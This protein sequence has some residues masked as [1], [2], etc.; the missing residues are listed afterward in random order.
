MS[1]PPQYSWPA[2]KRCA[3]VVSVLFDDG[4]DAV[5]IAPDLPSRSKSYSVWQ[6]G[7]RRGVDRLLQTLARLQVPSTWFVPGSVAQRHP[8]A[9]RAI[10][11]H[12]HELASHG[13][14]FE[15]YD[16]LDVA[17]AAK[18][19]R[20]SR[21]ILT[22]VSGQDVTGFRLPHGRWPRRFDAVL[23]SAGYRY[24]MSLNGDD[25]PYTHASGLVEIPVHSEL[26]DRPYFQFNFTPAFPPGHS[27]LPDYDGVLSN[28]QWEFD[29]YRQHGSCYVLPIHPEWIGSPGRIGLLERLLMDIRRHDDV[30]LT[31]AGAVAD[32]HAAQ[33]I[34]VPDTHPIAVYEEY[35]R[36]RGLA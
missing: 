30:W 31:T 32:W 10:A 2:G 3:V 26:D 22:D 19:L 9:V 11:A 15:R 12:S 16:T 13:M 4:V 29:A 27:R 14:G 24:S 8:D 21:Q 25:V 33:G 23:R 36:E 1:T 7:A 34:T 20:E 5:A 28:W 18:F 35:R 17:E 6:Y